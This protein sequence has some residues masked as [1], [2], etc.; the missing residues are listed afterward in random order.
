MASFLS[1][2]NAQLLCLRGAKDFAGISLLRADLE[3][4]M[5]RVERRGSPSS[6]MLNQKPSLKMEP[7]SVYPRSI[8]QPQYTD[9]RMGTIS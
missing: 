6:I 3:K 2:I 7:R 5:A 4:G 1:A 9:S 8:V